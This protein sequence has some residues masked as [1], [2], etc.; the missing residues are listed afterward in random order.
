MENCKPRLYC[1]LD[2]RTHFCTVCYILHVQLISTINSPLKFFVSLSQTSYFD[3]CS[4]YRVHFAVGRHGF[5]SF[6]MNF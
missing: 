1:S 2:H 4:G 5:K 3:I 6:V